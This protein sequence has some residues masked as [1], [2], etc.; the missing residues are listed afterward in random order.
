[1]HNIHYIIV[2]ASDHEEAEANALGQIES[3]GDENNWRC[4][5][6]SI[7]EDGK[8]HATGEGRGNDETLTLDDVRK[9]LRE[10]VHGK[11]WHMKE[12]KKVMRAAL[13]GK[14]ADLTGLDWYHV[15]RYAE[16]QQASADA[17]GVPENGD[18]DAFKTS[19]YAWAFNEFGITDLT[20]TDSEEP[21]FI[22]VIDMHS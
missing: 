12:A 19:Y 4:A 14:T 5:I 15:K 8:A 21:K 17:H 13:A 22:V 6:G 9:S 1:M 11:S 7:A 20:E 10:A 3:W 18:F 16:D 2:N